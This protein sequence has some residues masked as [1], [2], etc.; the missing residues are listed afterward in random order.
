MINR[1]FKAL[2]S[3]NLLTLY[4]LVTKGF[5]AA[6]KLMMNTYFQWAVVYSTPKIAKVPLSSLVDT[7]IPFKIQKPV[8]STGTIRTDELIAIASIVHH[9]KPL[10]ILEIGTCDGATT[11]NM[12]INCEEA[13]IFTIDLPLGYAETLLPESDLDLINRRLVGKSFISQPAAKRITQIYCDSAR[14]DFAEI[15]VFFDLIFIDGSHTY[16]YVKNDTEKTLPLLAP[17]AVMLWHDCC[18]MGQ[19]YGVY[20]YLCQHLQSKVKIIEGMTLAYYINKQE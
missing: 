13:A 16:E 4:I 18:A 2:M 12:A 8:S 6:T 3:S 15:G 19:N 9:K 7:N 14:Y 10:H 5:A 1:F 17:G 11:L 20:Q